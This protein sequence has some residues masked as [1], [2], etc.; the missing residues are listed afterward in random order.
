[1]AITVAVFQLQSVCACKEDTQCAS[2]TTQTYQAI[3]IREDLSDVIYRIT[4]TVT[5]FLSAIPK[6]K[7]A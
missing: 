5:P 2:S 6:I 1:L 4:P 3:G 7:A